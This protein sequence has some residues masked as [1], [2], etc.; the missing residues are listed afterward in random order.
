MKP[1]PKEKILSAVSSF[2]KVD[3]FERTKKREITFAR[4]VAM[5]LLWVF[6]GMGTVAIGKTFRKDHSTV[7][8][9]RKQVWNLCATNPEV[10]KDVIEIETQLECR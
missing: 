6:G 8:A 10:R 7:S 9:A 4:Q 3:L 1:I 2:Y 5:E